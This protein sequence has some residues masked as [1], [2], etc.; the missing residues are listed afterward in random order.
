MK[1]KLPGMTVNV[2]NSSDDYPQLQPG[3]SKKYSF[4]L[5]R[6]EFLQRKKVSVKTKQGAKEA[7]NI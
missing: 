3:R 6:R 2:K 4:I 7:E 1:E 5:V